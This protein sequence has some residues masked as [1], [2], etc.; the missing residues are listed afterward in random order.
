MAIVRGVGGGHGT[1][2]CAAGV[3]SSNGIQA[4]QACAIC[5]RNMVHVSRRAYDVPPLELLVAFE[6]RRG[7]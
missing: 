4:W 5:M 3:A 6:P 2:I 1:N 7:T